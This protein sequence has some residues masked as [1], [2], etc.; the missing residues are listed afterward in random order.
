MNAPDPDPSDLHRL[1][2]LGEELRALFGEERRAIAALD[3]ERLEQLAAD[4]Q[5][6]AEALSAFRTLER[7]PAVRDLFAAIR[8][9][10]HATAVLAATAAEAVRTMLGYENTGA[11]DKR[12]RRT[13]N[14]P[15]GRTLVAL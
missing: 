2:L 7:I 5:R 12:A 11:Y 4:K 6:L 9:E 3:H 1:R 14:L 8:V 10:A 15:T 13:A